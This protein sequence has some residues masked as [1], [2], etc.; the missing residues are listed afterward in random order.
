[1]MKGRIPH[2]LYTNRNEKEIQTNYVVLNSSNPQLLHICSHQTCAQNV[3]FTSLTWL[4]TF[5]KAR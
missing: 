4:T 2:L 1:M 5:H 3:A